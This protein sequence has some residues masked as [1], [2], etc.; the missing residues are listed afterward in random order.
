VL[1]DAPAAPGGEVGQ[2]TVR[3]EI[4]ATCRKALPPYKVPAVLRF[5]AS[6]DVTAAGKIARSSNA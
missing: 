1:N 2:N 3:D 6:V 5:A 4:L